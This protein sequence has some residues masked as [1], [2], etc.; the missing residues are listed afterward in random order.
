MWQ[1]IREYWIPKLLFTA[2]MI[3]G[4][5]LII[6]VAGMP[7]VVDMLPPPLGPMTMFANDTTVRR[8]ALAAA[9]GLIVTAFVFF[10]PGGNISGKKRSPAKSSADTIAGA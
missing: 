1:R 7:F 6:L 10:R 2:T 4:L 9:I 3:L 5:T 8:S